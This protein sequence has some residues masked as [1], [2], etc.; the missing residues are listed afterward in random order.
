MT[1]WRQILAWNGPP[2][3]DP[4]DTEK[5]RSEPDFTQEERSFSIPYS[6]VVEGHISV[7]ANCKKQ[8]VALAHEGNGDFNQDDFRDLVIFGNE[9]Q[10]LGR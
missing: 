5:Y 2:E 7:L 8:A 6:E 1:N 4:Y 9:I 3:D 10:D